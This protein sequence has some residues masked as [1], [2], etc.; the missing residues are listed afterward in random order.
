V[1]ETLLTEDTLRRHAG[2]SFVKGDTYHR[3]GNVESFTVQG[4]VVE[5]VVVGTERY[6]VRIEVRG[7]HL[8]MRCSCPVGDTC[9]HTVAVALAYLDRAPK[10]RG[11]PSGL[12]DTR[13]DVTAWAT[14][15]D[16]T[17]ALAISAGVIV[18]AIARSI[19]P[20]VLHGLSLREAA[21]WSTIRRYI[22]YAAEAVAYGM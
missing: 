14:E 6:A 7:Q 16:V 9:K 21:A 17:H 18:P 8:S 19:N 1:L 20:Y 3:A 22:P 2:H 13:E 15:H 5:G 11:A 12:L 4:N 10:S